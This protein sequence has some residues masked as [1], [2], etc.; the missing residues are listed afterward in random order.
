M[1]PVQKVTREQIE[2]ALNR[3]GGHVSHVADYLM[4][5]RK[6]IYDRL[7]RMGKSAGMFR[8]HAQEIGAE[9]VRTSTRFGIQV[10]TMDTLPPSVP[11]SGSGYYRSASGDP[12]LS[13][14]NGASV[15]DNPALARLGARAK[16]R[17]NPARLHP[18]HQDRLHRLRLDVQSRLGREITGSQLLDML[19]EDG[20]DAFEEKLLGVREVARG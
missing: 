12:S 16:G 17:Q 11:D 13:A 19:F 8:E 2:E 7:K 3:F 20:I 1:P 4:V 14:M 15:D 9:G 18:D 6:V 5:N 10:D